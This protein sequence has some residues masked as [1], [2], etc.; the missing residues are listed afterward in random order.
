MMPIQGFIVANQ[1]LRVRPDLLNQP[2]YILK[3]KYYGI[4]TFTLS[5]SWITFIL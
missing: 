1:S 4:L 5:L 3:L 2:I